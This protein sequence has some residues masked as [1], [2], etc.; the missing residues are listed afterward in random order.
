MYVTDIIPAIA[1]LHIFLKSALIFKKKSP[2]TKNN[3]F[4]GRLWF[5]ILT[6]HSIVVSLLA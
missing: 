3:V 2:K 1:K 6:N 4:Y 5:I